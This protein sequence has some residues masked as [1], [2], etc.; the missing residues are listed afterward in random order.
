MV[1]Q[2]LVLSPHIV[3]FHQVPRFLPTVQRHAGQ[4]ARIVFCLYVTV[5]N[6]LRLSLDVRWDWPQPS[7]QPSGISG[8]SGWTIMQLILNSLGL[9]TYLLASLR[10]LIH[11][12]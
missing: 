8:Y 11:Y 3:G 2:W 4:Y 9:H 5:Q 12:V 10:M 1:V 7:L 6:A